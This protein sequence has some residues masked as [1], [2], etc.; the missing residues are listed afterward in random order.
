MSQTDETTAQYHMP[1]GLMD[2]LDEVDCLAE[3]E[4]HPSL[5]TILR[6]FGPS[7][8][9][10]VMMIVALVVVSPLSGIPLLS[11]VAGLTTM[12]QAMLD[13]GYGEALMEKLCWS[14]WVRVLRRTW[15]G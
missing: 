12:R 1:T 7:G 5:Q 8:A 4:D 11:S 6:A 3:G 13:H 9:L 14:N 2:L 10:P 15:G